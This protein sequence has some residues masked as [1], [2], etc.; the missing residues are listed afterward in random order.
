MRR[1]LVSLSLVFFS[2]C[3]RGPTRIGFRRP[4]PFCLVALLI[5]SHV[6]AQAPAPTSFVGQRIVEVQMVSEERPIEDPTVRA[7]I[8]THVGDALSM[9]HVRESITHIFG[10]GRFQDVQVNALAAAGGVS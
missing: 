6:F 9:T 10:L 2:Y 7:L 8:E 5:S 3:S 4:V 1:T